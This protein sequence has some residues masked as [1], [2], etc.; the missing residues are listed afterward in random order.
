MTD[1]GYK[2]AGGSANT[3]DANRLY[4]CLFSVGGSGT[5][6][7]NSITVRFAPV[8]DTAKYKCAIY[9]SSL[10]PLTNGVTE[11]R[12]G[13]SGT[14]NYT[15]NFSTK[16]TIDCTASY[17]LC[18]LMDTN[19]TYFY[20]DAGDA[21]QEKEQAGVTYPNFPSTFVPSSTNARKYTM[22]GT[23]GAPPAGLPFLSPCQDLNDWSVVDH[24]GGTAPHVVSSPFHHGSGS[25]ELAD[26]YNMVTIYI[27][28][29]SG[30]RWILVVVRE[31]RLPNP[32]ENEEF[33]LFRARNS[34][35]DEEYTFG[36]VNTG[37][38]SQGELF[39]YRAANPYWEYKGY[40]ET[41]E[42]NPQTFHIILIH[43]KSGSGNAVLQ[44]YL[45]GNLKINRSDLTFAT[46]A[47]YTFG[48]LGGL[49]TGGTITINLDCVKIDKVAFTADPYA[50]VTH[51][52]TASAGSNGSITPSGE[53][54]VT[55]GDDQPF[56]MTPD[57]GYHVDDVLVDSESYG[58][59]S[60]YT[61]HNVTAAHTISVSFAETVGH[62][63]SLDKVPLNRAKL[64]K[65]VL[66]KTRLDK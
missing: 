27:N 58:S 3:F 54:V 56:A 62:L 7:L 57:S 22:W 33:Y 60:S 2:T 55:E 6:E 17:V 59:I 20:Y 34:G 36:N 9:D 15:F 47:M 41:P 42:F 10:Q 66:D 25:I 4:G 38:S 28:D 49:K 31:S 65:T 64:D 37:V 44:V 63:G 24:D 21:D 52:I 61:F 1:F 23:Y 53:V 11:E 46:P 30:E 29:A 43:E 26:N 5:A 13:L 39:I 35:G 51:T 14:A 19:G 16:P 12:T 48:M 40:L 18:I 45:N 8:S 50:V 32:N